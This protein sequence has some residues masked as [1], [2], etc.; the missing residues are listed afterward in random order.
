MLQFFLDH[1]QF[2]LFQFLILMIL[3]FLFDQKLVY[4]TALVLIQHALFDRG[5]S[6]RV[7]GLVVDCHA[8]LDTGVHAAKILHN[9]VQISR[10]YLRLFHVS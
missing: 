6:Q 9:E 10:A 3:L 5:I 1:L 4:N 7:N 8:F 2:F